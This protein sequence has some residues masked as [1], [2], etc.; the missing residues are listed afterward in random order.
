[1]TIVKDM[2]DIKA[3]SGLW[4]GFVKG[5]GLRAGSIAELCKGFLNKTID[6]GILYTAWAKIEPRDIRDRAKKAFTQG[7]RQIP[8]PAYDAKTMTKDHRYLD[9][10]YVRFDPSGKVELVDAGDAKRGKSQAA[11]DKAAAKQAGKDAP[12]HAGMA[13]ADL[14][15]FSKPE[16]VNRN[17]RHVLECIQRIYTNLQGS[18]KINAHKMLTEG[19]AKIEEAAGLTLGLNPRL[20]ESAQVKAMAQSMTA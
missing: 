10:V 4:S 7:L 8:N 3:V 5:D 20:G 13:L 6:G 2:L 14:A 1:M 12:Q 17:V 11:Q 16:A 9:P 15:D 18:E 19:I